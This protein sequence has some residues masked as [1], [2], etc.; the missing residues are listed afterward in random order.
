M[1]NQLCNLIYNPYRAIDIRD[2]RMQIPWKKRKRTL[3]KMN[4]AAIFFY[5]KPLI[6]SPVLLFFLPFQADPKCGSTELLTAT[7]GSSTPGRKGP[8]KDKKLIG[9]RHKSLN[10]AVTYDFFFLCSHFTSKKGDT[11]QIAAVFSFPWAAI[12]DVSFLVPEVQR[13][14]PIRAESFL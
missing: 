12:G 5:W 11:F 8:K 9:D 10:K 6:S 2:A 7:F 3:E 13:K 14:S 1:T 4:S